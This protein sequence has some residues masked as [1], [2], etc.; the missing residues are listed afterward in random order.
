MSGAYYIVLDVPDPGFDTYVNGKFLAHH[1]SAL[2]KICQKIGLRK[3][4][5]YVSQALEDARIMIE[6]H[7]GD[8]DSIDI[9]DEKWFSVEEGIEFVTRLS[10]HIEAHSDSIK[11]AEKI[12]SDLQEYSQVLEQCK[13]IQAKW[14]L[15]VDF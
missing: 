14:H 13:R 15:D 3:F 4:D 5:D 6:E 11:D 8:P 1:S 7:G 2:N 12:L 9:P 10:S